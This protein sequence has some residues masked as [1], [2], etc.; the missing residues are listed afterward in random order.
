[1]SV[2]VYQLEGPGAQLMARVEGDFF[3]I[4]GLPLLDVLA[5]LREHGALQA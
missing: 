3:T 2:G 5:A 4:L 1:M